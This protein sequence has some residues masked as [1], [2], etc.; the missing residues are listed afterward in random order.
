MPFW[1]I[2][3]II[4]ASY[5][6]SIVGG[7]G[8]A[9]FNPSQCQENK[10]LSDMSVIALYTGISLSTFTVLYLLFFTDTFS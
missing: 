5:V 3:S 6:L 8:V 2:W 1:I 7:V 9:R 4:I 10:T